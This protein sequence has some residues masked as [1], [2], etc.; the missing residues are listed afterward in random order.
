M[1]V[2][3]PSFTSVPTS[4]GHILALHELRQRQVRVAFLHGRSR[5]WRERRRI[6]P[7]VLTALVIVA[8]LVAAT[9]VLN[10][11][12]QQQL[13]NSAAGTVHPAV[14][15]ATVTREVLPSS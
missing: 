4:D 13:L 5:S 7:A 1:V 12:H 3:D 2:S 15:G 9:C 6:W 8:L 10:A 14:D 11:F